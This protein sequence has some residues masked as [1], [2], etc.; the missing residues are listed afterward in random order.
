MRLSIKSFIFLKV[1]LQG[2]EPWQDYNFLA[3]MKILI[4]NFD[5]Y[6][7]K[8]K[9][10]QKIIPFFQELSNQIEEAKIEK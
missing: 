4:L 10:L 9:S 8:T 5:S 3:Y 2:L 6:F 7:H 1:R